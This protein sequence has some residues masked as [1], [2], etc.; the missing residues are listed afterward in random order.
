MTCSY[1]LSRNAEDDH[2]CRRCGRRLSAAGLRTDGALATAPA[3]EAL[4]DVH[5]SPRAQAAPQIQPSLFPY[6]PG[7]KIIPFQSIPGS[8]VE[9]APKATPRRTPRLPEEDQQ[10]LDFVPADPKTPRTLRTSVEATI[11]C[12]APV[13]PPMHRA[14]AAAIDGSMVLI[15]FGVFIAT[16]HFGAGQ[17]AL[18]QPNLVVVGGAYLILHLFYGLLW[19]LA[20]R[21]TPGMHWTQLRFIDFDGYPVGLSRRILRYFATAFSVCTVLG[22]V[23]GIV[24]EESLT[25]QDRVTRTF[26]T[27]LE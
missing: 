17:F 2:R 6:R 8:R 3:P 26:P 7:G 25:W 19:A 22:V 14:V 16:F 24:D 13:A 27:V 20:G 15:A 21:E 12:D 10:T 1:C 9:P 18:T 5:E 23:W 11:Y 4:S